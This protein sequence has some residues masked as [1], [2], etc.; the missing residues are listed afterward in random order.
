MGFSGPVP[1]IPDAVIRVVNAL[2]AT[3]DGAEPAGPQAQAR[4]GALLLV[5]PGIGRFLVRGGLTIDL[6]ADPGADP[7]AVSLVLHGSARGALIHQRGELPLHAA[8]LVPPGGDAACAICGP[9]GAGKSTLAAELSR[10]GWTLVADDTTRVT[11]TAAGPLAWPSRDSIKLWRDACEAKGIEVARLEQV[12]AGLDKHYLRVPA[13]DEPAR[14]AA[15]F[16]LLIDG[17]DDVFFAANKEKMAL[18]TRH[19]YRQAQIRPLGRIA[20]YVRIVANVAGACRFQGLGG[21]RIRPVT[22][23]ADAVESAMV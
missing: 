6:A 3:L 22:V 8:T 16:E 9:S 5:S 17:A 19:T 13:R 23:L 12:C 14:L 18:L 7:G 4:A 20:D 10:R 1:G 21:A 15:V 2:S 11:W